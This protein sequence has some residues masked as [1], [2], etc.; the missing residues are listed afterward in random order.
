MDDKQKAFDIFDAASCQEST[1]DIYCKILAE[2]AANLP[3]TRHVIIRSQAG[4]ALSALHHDIE[5]ALRSFRYLAQ[6]IA[7]QYDPEDARGQKILAS[8]QH[9][10]ATMERLK[11]EIIDR[12]IPLP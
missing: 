10:L 11:A 2:L 4:D 1:P 5:A 6:K 9:H 3:N 12:V 8:I 7:K